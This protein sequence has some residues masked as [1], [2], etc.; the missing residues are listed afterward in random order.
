MTLDDRVTQLEGQVAQ[1]LAFKQDNET[2][3]LRMKNKV[4]DLEREIATLK[5][6]SSGQRPP[7]QFGDLG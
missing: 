5:Q 4:L 3:M 7:V 1:L 6:Q 2:R